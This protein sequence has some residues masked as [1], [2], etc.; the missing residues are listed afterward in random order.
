MKICSSLS[1]DR[2]SFP[3]FRYGP[4]R[5]FCAVI[6]S[7]SD[8]STP[9]SRGRDMTFSASSSVTVAGSMV[10]SRDAVFGLR[11]SSRISLIRF[12]FLFSAVLVS[13]LSGFLPSS[14]RAASSASR[15]ASMTFSASAVTR[16]SS[17]SFTFSVTYG[18]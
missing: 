5:P 15:S 18:P 8:G 16:A 6:I 4:N 3:F 17:S 1:S 13:R 9:T 14:A 7:P 12:A 2:E 11:V 10:F